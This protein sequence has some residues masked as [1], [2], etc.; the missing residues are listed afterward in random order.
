MSQQWDSGVWG[1]FS[2]TIKGFGAPT[3]PHQ[4]FDQPN[5][6]PALKGLGHRRGT[7]HMI[8]LLS[9]STHFAMVF[10]GLP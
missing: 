6:D 3:C 9:S 8:M 2:P 10:G 4:Y 7:N 5:E 1:Q